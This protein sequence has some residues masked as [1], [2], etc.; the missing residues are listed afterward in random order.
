MRLPNIIA[1]L[2]GFARPAHVLEEQYQK[3][4]VWDLENVSHLVIMSPP[5]AFPFSSICLVLSRQIFTYKVLN[6]S[7]LNLFIEVSTEICRVSNIF[8]KL[9]KYRCIIIW[10]NTDCITFLSGFLTVIFLQN[11]FHPSIHP[12]LPDP[13]QGSNLEKWHIFTPGYITGIDAPPPAR[14]RD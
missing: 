14:K 12:C 2:K 5:K 11:D 4:F 3:V 13:Y 1:E 8:R 9:L 10:Q 6:V 7:M